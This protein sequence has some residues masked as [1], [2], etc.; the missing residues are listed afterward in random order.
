MSTSRVCHQGR[1]SSSLLFPG[2]PAGERNQGLP[3]TLVSRKCGSSPC[4]PRSPLLKACSAS[5]SAL[6]ES[7]GPSGSKNPFHFS[8][9][10]P[11]PLPQPLPCSL[12]VM[13]PG[14]SALPWGLPTFRLRPVS[15][16]P[17][18]GHLRAWGPEGQKGSLPFLASPLASI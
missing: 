14:H 4:L 3:A 17:S 18:H 8:P 13:S 1:V 15:P 10:P 12:L 11:L 2:T 5:S 9:C 7:P 16:L 6:I